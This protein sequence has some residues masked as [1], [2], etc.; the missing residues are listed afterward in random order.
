MAII[1]SLTYITGNDVKLQVARQVMQGSGILVR[2]EKLRP[3]EIQSSRV[4]EVAEYS[5]LWASERLN[6]PIA[7]MDA[8]F[9][10]EALN[11]FPGPFIKYVNEWFSAEDY[12][13]LMQGKENRRLLIRDCLAYCRPGEKPV[14]LLAEYGGT[15]ATEASRKSGT[16]I[17]QVFIP[18]GYT[19]PASEIPAEEMIAYWSRV[20]TWRQLRRFLEA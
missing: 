8:G 11:G 18:D 1:D 4:E 20:S 9:Y 6:R 19:V 13:H 7:V 15:I 3:P 10:I 16:P 12:L 17:E 2:Q 5:A 14:I